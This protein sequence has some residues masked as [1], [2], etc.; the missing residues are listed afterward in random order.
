MFITEIGDND[1]ICTWLFSSHSVLGAGVWW[2]LFGCWLFWCGPPTSAEHSEQDLTASVCPDVW[3]S[4]TWAGWCFCARSLHGRRLWERLARVAAV[5]VL[6][7]SCSWP[8][9][10]APGRDGSQMWLSELSPPPSP[11][12]HPCRGSLKLDAEQAAYT[13][14]LGVNTFP[15]KGGPPGEDSGW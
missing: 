2:W 8:R 12:H 11:D 14:V 5:A 15:G 13:V 10:G 4:H 1:L 3:I 6:P 7:Q 9:A